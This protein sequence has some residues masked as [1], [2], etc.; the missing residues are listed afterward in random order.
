MNFWVPSIVVGI[1][2]TGVY[3]SA[4][5]GTP[6]GSWIRSGVA[7]IAAGSHMGYRLHRRWLHLAAQQCRPPV[8]VLMVICDVACLV[9]GSLSG[10]GRYLFLTR[11]MRV[12]VSSRGQQLQS[13]QLLSPSVFVNP[14]LWDFFPHFLLCNS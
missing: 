6:A 14:Y 13:P 7:G 4:F 8:S 1:Q 5:L 11:L 2:Y 9:S 3:S 12:F 10:L